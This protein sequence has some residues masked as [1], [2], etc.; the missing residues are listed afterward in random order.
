MICKMCGKDFMDYAKFCPYCGSEVIKE[1]YTEILD[2]LSLLLNGANPLTG[3]VINYN[4]LCMDEEYV[5]LITL[6]YKS[7]SNVKKTNRKSGRDRFGKIE[8]VN[9]F[10]RNTN[11]LLTELKAWRTGI[12]ME[13]HLPAYTVFSDDDLYN[14]ANGDICK[15]EQLLLIKGMGES[16]YD[17]YGDDIFDIIKPFIKDSDEDYLEE[18]LNKVKMIKEHKERAKANLRAKYPNI[19]KSWSKE[20]DENLKNEFEK[21]PTLNFSYYA[22]MFGR[23]S[24]GIKARLRRLHLIAYDDERKEYYI[25]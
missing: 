16:K 8:S 3:E 11:K 2:A 4:E 6:L 20:D 9:R 7:L 18:I 15:K 23:S 10:N 12:S 5:K 22:Q 19:G 13:K 21:N 17:Q 1:D 14:I 25:I 24:D